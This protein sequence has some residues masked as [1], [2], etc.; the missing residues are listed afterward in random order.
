[1]NAFIV[2]EC[3]R[4]YVLFYLL[5][6]F[7]LKPHTQMAARNGPNAVEGQLKRKPNEVYSSTNG[8]HHFFPHSRERKTWSKIR[9]GRGCMWLCDDFVTAFLKP[10]GS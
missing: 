3:R 5:C 4:I 2:H 10:N 6:E 9:D 1:M 7:N 8:N